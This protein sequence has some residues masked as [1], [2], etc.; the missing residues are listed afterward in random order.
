MPSVDSTGFKFGQII[1]DKE[2][3][4]TKVTQE[5][6]GLDLGT[7]FGKLKEAKMFK[8]DQQKESIDFNTKKLAAL[9]DFKSKALE[10][11]KA[12]ATM[13]N[14]LGNKE[15]INNVMQQK[16]LNVTASGTMRAESLV[17]IDYFN[18]AE[19]GAF[20]MKVNQIAKAD[21]YQTKISVSDFNG[22]LGL[23]GKFTIGTIATDSSAQITITSDMTLSQVTQSINA[24]SSKTGVSAS[25]S[26]ISPSD[27]NGYEFRLSTKQLSTPI[28]LQDDS[29]GIL[30]GWNLIPN[31]QVSIQSGPLG[32][33]NNQTADLNLTGDLVVGAGGGTPLTIDTNGLSLKDIAKQINDKSSINKV[34]ASIVPIYA[35]NAL[36]SDLPIG[37]GLSLS[38]TNNQPLNLENS[39]IAVISKLQLQSA[40]NP[41][42]NSIVSTEDP[43]A[44]LGV[45]GKLIVQAGPDGG[46]FSIDTDGKSLNQIVQQINDNTS[47][48]GVFAKLQILIPANPSV[49]G[50]KNVY[51]LTLA[52]NNGTS[53]ITSASDTSAFSGLGLSAPT[54]DYQTM[55]AKVNV[56]G[57]DY[58]RLTNNVD[59]VITGLTFNLKSADTATTLNV[60][61]FQ[62]KDGAMRGLDA[63]MNA[64]NDLNAFFKKQTAMKDDYSGPQE[65]AL[66]YDNLYIKTFMQ[67]LQQKLS[68]PVVGPQ[69]GSLI[70]LSSIGLKINFSDGA[71]VQSDEKLWN[72]AIN[73]NY[74]NLVALFENTVTNTNKSFQLVEVPD[75]IDPSIAGKDIKISLGKDSISGIASATIEVNGNTY[76]ASITTKG[77]LITIQT[78]GTGT[79][80]DNFKFQY[81][82]DSFKNGDTVTTTF[83]I[84]AGIM[85]QVDGFLLTETDSNKVKGDNLRPPFDVKGPMLQDISV[86]QEKNKKLA[87]EAESLKK[88]VEKEMEV[89]ERR[90]DA[91]MKAKANYEM[92]QGL[93][94]SFL[95]ANSN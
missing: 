89:I 55:V 88:T 46:A 91:V 73:K 28:V 19:V 37:Y 53:L 56:N 63:V 85:A 83:N 30:T 80:L 27:P 94:K 54:H 50:S 2:S 24:V 31:Q 8:V 42:I 58:Q 16:A 3:G 38:T 76:D 59:D 51:Q 70:S 43:A 57:V 22:A 41:S 7:Y 4:R 32:I 34:A 13:A 33:T 9:N 61:V 36:S 82:S 15:K 65:G 35:V 68:T 12:V 26:L 44:D 74:D 67:Q 64:Y 62:D 5:V 48:T 49:S 84:V 87:E 1:V 79:T 23:S 10:L 18:E 39:N 86:L 69:N 78:T 17:Q 66:L 21:S 29:G 77:S 20:K 25:F 40:I 14:R 47:T 93:L 95:K 75:I 45:T 72:D 90:F 81:S 60:E 92:V 71:L 52:T 11:D 6:A